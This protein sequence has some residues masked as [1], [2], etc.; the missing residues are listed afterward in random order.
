M[1]KKNFSP[2]DTYGVNETK[3]LKRVDDGK[4]LK[5]LRVSADVAFP[6]QPDASKFTLDEQLKAGVLPQQVRGYELP[7][8]ES[9][10]NQRLNE[11]IEDYDK[12]NIEKDE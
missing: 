6:P 10:V 9:E 12:L 7:P 4:H 8:K 11:F 2:N 5:I 1:F 3:F